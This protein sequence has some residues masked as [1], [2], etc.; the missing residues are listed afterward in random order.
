MASTLP[1]EQVPSKDRLIT[2]PDEEPL[3]TPLDPA[4][5]EARGYP[6]DPKPGTAG[7]TSPGD[8]AGTDPGARD[9]GRTT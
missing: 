5:P 9:L 3:P 8:P 1:P 6:A 7:E 4:G 2:R